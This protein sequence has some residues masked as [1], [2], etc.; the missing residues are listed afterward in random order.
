MRKRMA[1]SRPAT[2]AAA[3]PRARRGHEERGRARS[4]A[5]RPRRSPRCAS[6]TLGT[7]FARVRAAEAGAPT[8]ALV[9]HIDEIG[10]AITHVERRTGCSRS[11][12]LGGISPEA[13]HGQRVELLTRD[14]RLPAAIARKRLCP[15]SARSRP[16][17]AGRPAHRH[18]RDEPRRGARAR[19][20]RRR[21]RLASGRRS[22][23]R[24]AA[25][26][27]KALDNRLGAYVALEAARRVAEAGGARS[28]WSR[29]R[30]S[31][32][33]IGLA[34][35]AHRRLRARPA[36][37]D[38][39]RRHAARPTFPDGDAAAAGPH[40]AGLRRDDRARADR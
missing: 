9:G 29:S 33:E 40:R 17:R 38:R 3:R 4:G 23:S 6:D 27:S 18:R 31:Q 25:S 13:L 15:S 11:R 19:P 36:G 34:R 32:E 39:R 30:R 1:A 12:T 7:S 20:R 16:P 14:G 21:R 10:V 26:L 24:T 35:R 5:R 37:R 2:R 8:L 28:T 22:S